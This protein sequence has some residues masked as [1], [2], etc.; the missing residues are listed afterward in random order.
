MN[1]KH[2]TFAGDF[3]KKTEV[4]IL[5][6]IEA[7]LERVGDAALRKMKT[8]TEPHDYRGDIEGG[9]SGSLAWRTAHNH[10]EV[11]DEKDLI[12][13]PPVHAVDI[14]S[15]NGHAFVREY[16]SGPHLNKEG[17]PEFIAEIIEWAASR[18]PPISEEGAW[19]IIKTIRNEGTDEA[20]FVR[21]VGY[22]MRSIALPICR[23]A[24]STYWASQRQV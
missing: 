3:L 16:G 12:E 21:P 11:T 17:S 1:T 23:E 6:P 24:I 9:L 10:S 19:A 18:N 20:P 22:Q 5:R 8:Y 13:A 7:V 2:V 4:D 15:A 14:G